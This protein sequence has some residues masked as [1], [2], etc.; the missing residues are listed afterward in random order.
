MTIIDDGCA[1]LLMC[2][3]A[4]YN[5]HFSP[6]SSTQF[7]LTLLTRSL[8]SDKKVRVFLNGNKHLL[9]PSD[10]LHFICTYTLFSFFP[11]LLSMNVMYSRLL[12]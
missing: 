5:K 11:L 7:I 4:S 10:D 8:I 3:S 6:V 9:S 12:E 1:V 2:W